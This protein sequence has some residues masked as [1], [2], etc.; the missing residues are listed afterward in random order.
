[1]QMLQADGLVC[2][3]M[4]HST[5]DRVDVWTRVEQPARSVPVCHPDARRFNLPSGNVASVAWDTAHLSRNVPVQVVATTAVL[6]DRKRS[7]CSAGSKCHT[8]VR[9]CS[10]EGMG[11]VCMRVFSG[12]AACLDQP[13][14]DS[15]TS[16]VPIFLP[17]RR[18]GV[19]GEGKEGVEQRGMGA[20]SKL[21]AIP[22]G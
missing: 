1:M 12:V 2:M 13:R 10:L 8:P 21:A 15:G 4:V 11:G 6:D 22:S 5:T 16:A 3:C 9:H 17:T 20:V 18:R 19:K 7:L 14:I